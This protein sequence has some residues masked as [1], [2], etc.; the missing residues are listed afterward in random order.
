MTSRFGLQEVIPVG[1]PRQEQ[2]VTV[3]RIYCESSEGKI[4]SAS[5]LLE[6]R[7][8]MVPRR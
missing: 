6:V 2:V 3:G 8:E 7:T 5:I 4:N 1:V